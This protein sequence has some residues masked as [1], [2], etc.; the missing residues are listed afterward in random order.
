MR[1]LTKRQKQIFDFIISFLDSN[2]FPPT[3][4]DISNY[5][6]FKS[7]NAANDHL[8]CLQKKGFIELIPGVA[9][10]IKVIRA[11]SPWIKLDA[12]DKETWPKIDMVIVYNINRRSSA[13]T[14]VCEEWLNR[15]ILINKE[16]KDSLCW[17]EMPGGLP[18]L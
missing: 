4:L 5:F 10:N 9:R 2:G 11:K 6:G 13:I 1:D 16:F 17:F 12:D 15:L 18:N 14:Y 3:R 7:K 8:L